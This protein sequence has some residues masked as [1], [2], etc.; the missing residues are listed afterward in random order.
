MIVQMYHTQTLISLGKLTN[1]V[2]N[3]VEKNIE[4][5]Q[6][7]IEILKVL[8]EKTRGNLSEDE[9]KLFEESLRNLQLNVLAISKED[10]STTPEN[11][12]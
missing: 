2:T 6:L 10:S 9:K 8:E 5:A 11:S 1:P 4:Q 12:Q 3:A 7:L